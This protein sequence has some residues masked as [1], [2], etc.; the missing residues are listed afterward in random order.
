MFL[1]PFGTAQK[2]AS[3]NHKYAWLHSTRNQH[4]PMIL[5]H[6]MMPQRARVT[7]ADCGVFVVGVAA[8]TAGDNAARQHVAGHFAVSAHG[9]AL[10]AQDRRGPDTTHCCKH[11]QRVCKSRY[12]CLRAIS[13]CY[14]HMRLTQ[15]NRCDRRNLR[16]EID[17]LG[18]F[19]RATA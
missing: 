10:S 16:H 13:A 5:L 3:R 7:A 15:A 9:K 8:E 1:H 17:F 6:A 2:A 18:N 19:V 12:R 4:E 14:M 11:R